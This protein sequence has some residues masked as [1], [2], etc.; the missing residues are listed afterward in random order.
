M[1]MGSAVLDGTPWNWIPASHSCTINAHMQVIEILKDNLKDNSTAIHEEN[2]WKVHP[3]FNSVTFLQ[4]S[5][6]M[7]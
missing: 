1:F 6:I 3:H 7:P 2:I 5:V 4:E